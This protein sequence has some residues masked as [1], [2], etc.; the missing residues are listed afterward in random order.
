MLVTDGQTN[1]PTERP[2]DS[3]CDKPLTLCATRPN[4]S[5]T[6]CCCL[7]VLVDNVRQV[8][9]FDKRR[10]PLSARDTSREHITSRAPAQSVG[11]SR[12]E[13]V[14]D[15]CRRR[16]CPAAGLQ[17]VEVRRRVGGL[18][19]A[20]IFRRSPLSTS[21]RSRSAAQREA[22]VARRRRRRRRQRGHRQRL[23]CR[24]LGLDRSTDDGR[25]RGAGSS[26]RPRSDSAAAERRTAIATEFRRRRRA[27]T[28]RLVARRL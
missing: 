11:A 28:R 24:R 12:G 6:D 22:D 5:D 4:N 10:F 3:I 13:G 17:Q 25:R 18:R 26:R 7:R 1:G 9:Q 14:A 21:H 2:R 19:H 20:A 8:G 16:R 15:H 27:A 23:E